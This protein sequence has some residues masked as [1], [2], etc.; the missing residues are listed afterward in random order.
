[1]AGSINGGSFMLAMYVSLWEITFIEFVSQQKLLFVAK[2][3]A[4]TCVS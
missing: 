2:I 3:I 4:H 1:M